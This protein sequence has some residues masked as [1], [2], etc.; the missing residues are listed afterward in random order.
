MPGD[1]QW[2]LAWLGRA[3]EQGSK[4]AP[5]PPNPPP[6]PRPPEPTPPPL[7]PYTLLIPPP[8]PVSSGLASVRHNKAETQG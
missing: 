6:P 5:A 3:G 8:R 1:A 4:G 7:T 2:K